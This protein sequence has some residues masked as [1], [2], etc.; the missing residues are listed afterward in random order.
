MCS[1]DREHIGFGSHREIP[2]E[3]G[4]GP[5]MYCTYKRKSLR[6]VEFDPHDCLPATTSVDSRRSS[7]APCPPHHC[8]PRGVACGSVGV[9][10]LTPRRWL[11]MGL[12]ARPLAC[13]PLPPPP[14]PHAVATVS[15]P[16]AATPGI[17][18]VA[19][20]AVGVTGL[21]GGGRAGMSRSRPSLTAAVVVRNGPGGPCRTPSCGL[22][23]GGG[24]TRWVRCSSAGSS[25]A[26]AACGLVAG[27][28]RAAA[29]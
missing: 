21:A 23:G 27:T 19:M 15:P 7:P 11:R 9:R 13:P 18:L 3:D 4:T 16:R 25:R 2:G 26:S 22:G 5:S 12:T 1:W 10:G 20:M 24:C 29:R 28:G 8:R 17:P 14:P 6:K